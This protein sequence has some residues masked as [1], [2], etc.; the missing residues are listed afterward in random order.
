MPTTDKPTLARLNGA[1]FR[2]V[3]ES[4]QT[5]NPNCRSLFLQHVATA[6]LH[7]EDESVGDGDCARAVRSAL[8]LLHHGRLVQL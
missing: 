6:L 3:L 7:I 2:S 4:A 1:Q 5:L 8:A